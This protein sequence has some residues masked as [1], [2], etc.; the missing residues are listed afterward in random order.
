MNDENLLELFLGSDGVWG[1][2]CEPVHHSWHEHDGKII[3]H[4]A[5][6]SS[7]GMHKSG[8]SLQPLCGVHPSLIGLNLG[9]F[10]ITGPLECLECHCECSGPLGII[11]ICGIASVEWLEG[12]VWVPKLL[13]VLFTPAY[14][15]FMATKTAPIDLTSRVLEVVE[16]RSDVLFDLLVVLMRVADVVPPSSP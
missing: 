14:F 8:I 2:A 15:L 16:V 6:I 7:G 11:T 12:C 4:D 13:L 1:K 5:C 10:E 9:D 3:C